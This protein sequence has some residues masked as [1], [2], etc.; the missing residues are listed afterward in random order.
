MVKG[1]HLRRECKEITTGEARRPCRAHAHTGR[2]HL[3]KKLKQSTHNST[4]TPLQETRP[5][6]PVV[7]FAS[8]T[9]PILARSV[10][11][12]PH[13]PPPASL[14]GPPSS[15][16]VVVLETQMPQLGPQI[17]AARA[18]IAARSPVASEEQRL[19]RGGTH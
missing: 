1:L 14:P 3:K 5:P 8:L 12:P 4:H 17:T 6:V 11:H 18:N 15:L 2:P 16:H 9:A 7:L 13:S 19:A 10:N